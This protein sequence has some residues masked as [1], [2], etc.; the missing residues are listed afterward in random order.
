MELSLRMT[1]R[2]SKTQAKPEQVLRRAPPPTR[3]ASK[4]VK[5]GSA[6]QAS[7]GAGW[8]PA[9]A[10][11]VPASGRSAPGRWGAM[12]WE[13][14]ERSRG[15]PLKVGGDGHSCHWEV[16]SSFS[17]AQVHWPHD[18]LS[19]SRCPPRDGEDPTQE[20]RLLWLLNWEQ[21]SSQAK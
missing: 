3:V 12:S 16:V 7:G 4:A 1:G 21:V 2:A 15:P 17:G 19:H 14:R 20:P 6:H 5:R 11:L 8:S 9:E 13:D 18:Q 10:S